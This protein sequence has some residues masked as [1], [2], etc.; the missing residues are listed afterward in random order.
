LFSAK[1]LERLWLRGYKPKSRDLGCMKVF[2]N[3]ADDSGNQ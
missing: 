1:S 3:L 2:R